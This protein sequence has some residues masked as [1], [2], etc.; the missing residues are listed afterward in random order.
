M[1]LL[2]TPP[3]TSWANSDLTSAPTIDP[4]VHGAA[5]SPRLAER[6]AS[7]VAACPGHNA[8]GEG[9]R[10]GKGPN[11]RARGSDLRPNQAGRRFGYDITLEGQD[12]SNT[13][14]VVIDPDLI[15][16]PITPAP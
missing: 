2:S 12:G 6:P 7:K 9:E 3:R 11:A 10:G 15:I 13:Y 8:R 16:T 1:A 5:V 4:I 14:T